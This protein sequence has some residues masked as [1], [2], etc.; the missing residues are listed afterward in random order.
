M[1]IPCLQYIVSTRLFPPFSNVNWEEN[2][3]KEVKINLEKKYFL[4]NFMNSFDDDD[5]D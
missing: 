4:M 1:Q 3:S 5:D 2:M